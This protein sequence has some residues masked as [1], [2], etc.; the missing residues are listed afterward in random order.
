MGNPLVTLGIRVLWAYF[1]ILL[2]GFLLPYTVFNGV[3][4]NFMA[5]LTVILSGLKI[6]QD[7]NSQR[8]WIECDSSSAVGATN[9]KNYLGFF[10]HSGITPQISFKTFNRKF[11]ASIGKEIL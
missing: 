2:E 3:Q 5:K 4:N 10:F 6:A 11:C 7:Q 8:L 1:G 9:S